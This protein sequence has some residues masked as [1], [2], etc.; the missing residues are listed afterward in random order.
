M[1]VRI[2]ANIIFPW[3]LRPRCQKRGEKSSLRASH[4][5][6]SPKEG[7]RCVHD[8]TRRKGSYQTDGSSAKTQTWDKKYEDKSNIPRGFP[9][10]WQAERCT[11]SRLLKFCNEVCN[12]SSWQ[13]RMITVWQLNEFCNKKW[14]VHSNFWVFHLW[15]TPKYMRSLESDFLKQYFF[16][17]SFSSW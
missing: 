8:Q 4:D 16:P 14:W 11:F 2:W 10:L 6:Q 1:S 17:C 3:C 13:D 9:L 15:E 7:T 5:A 12:V